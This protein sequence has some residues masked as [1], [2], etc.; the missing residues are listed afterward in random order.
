ME[1]NVLR[2]CS[3]EMFG[4]WRAKTAIRT[5]WRYR[6]KPCGKWYHM[7]YETMDLFPCCDPSNK[8]LVIFV[9]S[10]KMLTDHVTSK[11]RLEKPAW[12]D[13]LKVSH[14]VLLTDIKHKTNL[15]GIIVARRTRHK[16]AC[17]RVCS[18]CG[19]WGHAGNMMN[20]PIR[21]MP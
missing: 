8:C 16:H 12:S 11:Q 21:I 17:A 4:P 15:Q 9:Q 14:T 7:Y 3:S 19:A 18:V 1:R 2:W 5:K 10:E 6:Q 13:L 20:E